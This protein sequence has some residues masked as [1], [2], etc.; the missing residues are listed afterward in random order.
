M[1][2][3][4]T[5]Q[6]RPIQSVSWRFRPTTRDG[7]KGAASRRGR[8]LEHRLPDLTTNTR[9]VPFVKGVIVR[10]KVTRSSVER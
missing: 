2:D 7:L 1:I 10:R 4:R 8:R 9:C 6:E 5:W 3:R